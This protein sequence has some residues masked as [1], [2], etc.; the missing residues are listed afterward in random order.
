MAMRR[1]RHKPPKHLGEMR[2][3][4]LIT[5]YGVGAM[6]D[7]RDETGILAEADK[8]YSPDDS[9]EERVIRCHS[10]EKLL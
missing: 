2:T 5:S 4:Q 8:W 6:V 3:S 1:I 10:L 9:D 7:F